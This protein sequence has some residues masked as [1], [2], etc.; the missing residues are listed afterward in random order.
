MNR[1]PALAFAAAALV[2][3]AALADT[4]APAVDPSQ[5]T[6][7][8]LVQSLPGF[9]EGS[10]EVNGISLHYVAGGE[11]PPVFLL[12]GWP[13][14]WWE[15]HRLMP[16][17]ARTHR[18]VSIDLR[19]M[20]ASD[21]PAAGY[22]K[23]SM[24]SDIHALAKAL[25]YDK[26]DLVGH[27]IGSMVAFAYAANYP[28]ATGKVVMMDVPHPDASLT[29]WTLLPAVGAFRDKADAQH[30]YPWWFAYHQVKGLPEEL[31]AGKA[32]VTQKWFFHYLMQDDS[33]LDARDRAV[34]AAHYDSAD[35][36]RAGDAWYQAFPQDILD[37]ESYP[38][39]TAPILAL[40][41]PGYAWMKASLAMHASA[42]T[43]VQVPDTGHFIP[44][45]QPALT[46]AQVSGFLK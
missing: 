38:K 1:I 37:G 27:D 24:A 29:S 5:I 22:E 2:P 28:E 34:Y 15:W 42:V 14:T 18:V 9:R 3:L 39:V 30:A 41:G 19:G 10:A 33:K 44:D 4:P 8:A 21:R 13:Q 25:G 43:L 23:K 7:A 40:G 16:E 12:P 46:F 36:I 17:L 6:D 32:A 11:G 26:V 20:G 35:Q 45:E 31:G